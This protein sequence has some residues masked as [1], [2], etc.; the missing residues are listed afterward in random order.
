MRCFGE[1]AGV[2]RRVFC[3]VRLK[4][5]NPTADAGRFAMSAS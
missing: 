5:E 1:P 2:S 3:T 4:V